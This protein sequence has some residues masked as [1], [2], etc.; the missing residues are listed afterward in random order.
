[1]EFENDSPKL[2]EI[3][4]GKEIGK[5]PSMALQQFIWHPCIVCGTP[6]WVPVRDGQPT[7]KRCRICYGIAIRGKNAPR[8][9][10]GRPKI[11][12]GYIQVLLRPDDFFYP[13][14]KKT[15]HY[16][17]EHRLIMARHLRR[18]LLSW[19]CV[20]HKNGIRDDNRLENLE[21]LGC[22]G[23]HNTRIN[24][25]LKEQAK[26]INEL[27]ILVKLLLWHIQGI[28]TTIKDNYTWVED[29]ITE[30][31]ERTTGEQDA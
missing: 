31:E 8:W 14:A 27:Q 5:R 18:C 24:R 12:S 17:L 15:D 9:K 2:N 20:H 13:M 22:T 29:S 21:L 23:Q 19:E 11:G 10:G 16:V 28:H 30:T 4:R 7:S 1:M 6:R 3:R 25:Q 26:Q